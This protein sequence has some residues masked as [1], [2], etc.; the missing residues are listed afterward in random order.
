MNVRVRA[1]M[2]AYV[3]GQR[4]VEGHVWFVRAR[5]EWQIKL[6]PAQMHSCDSDQTTE[7]RQH[8]AW[9]ILM[10]YNPPI[11]TTTN[12]TAAAAAGACTH[13]GSRRI[14]QLRCEIR[15]VRRQPLSHSA[16]HVVILAIVLE[17]APHPMSKILQQTCTRQRTR[18]NLQARLR[19]QLEQRKADL[20]GDRAS[21]IQ[22][23]RAGSQ[24]VRRGWAS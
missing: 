16:I 14:R 11:T 4:R 10:E 9:T 22:T 17:M 20:V 6:P 21:G 1:R 2:R 15:F 12:I 5:T 8:A 7:C 3:E 13:Q 19:G 23:S 24:A 18:F